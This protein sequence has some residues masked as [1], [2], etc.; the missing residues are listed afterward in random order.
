MRA[1]TDRRGEQHQALPIDFAC[2]HNHLEAMRI[3]VEAGVDAGDLQMTLW[4]C[5]EGHGV[6]LLVNLLAI[7]VDPNFH[8]DGWDCDVLYGFLQTYHRSEPDRLHRAINALI[9]AGARYEDGPV[10]DLHRG[11]L[12]RLREHLAADSGLAARR[13]QLDYGDHLTLRGT[14]LLHVA[15]EYHEIEAIDLLLEHGA[16]LD[17]PAEIGANGVGGQSPLFHTIGANQGTGW[18]TFLHL[19]NRGARLDVR[20][21][22]QVSP[23]DDDKVM[24]CV[25]KGRDH[26][27]DEVLEQTPLGYALRYESGPGWRETT[28]EVTELRRRAA[29]D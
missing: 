17:S 13:F 8:H 27:F 29:P 24:D 21:R 11:D 1:F 2:R 25:H 20:A 7:G 3:L 23:E 4:G 22:V 9:E 5:V 18:E 12:D 6:D 16:E 15:A 26:H 28:R 19:L 14:T 10:M